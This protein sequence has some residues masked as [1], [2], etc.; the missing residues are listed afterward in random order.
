LA[1]YLAA[2]NAGEHELS[3]YLRTYVHAGEDAYRRAVDPERLAG[4]SASVQDWQE[5]FR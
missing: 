1:A 3:A 4:W 5:L 2:A